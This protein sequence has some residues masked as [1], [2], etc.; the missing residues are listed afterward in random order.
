MS[1]GA[2]EDH[3]LNDKEKHKA[4]LFRGLVIPKDGPV[5]G[6][7]R[8]NSEKDLVLDTFISNCAENL[9]HQC[10]RLTG[11]STMILANMNAPHEYAFD[12]RSRTS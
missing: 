3:K 10:E 7:P 5:P 12:G 11:I 8:E 2:A 1:E 4:A 9:V 6:C